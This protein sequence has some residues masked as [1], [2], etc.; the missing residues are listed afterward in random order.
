MV[1][2]PL[3]HEHSTQLYIVKS[4]VF[5]SIQLVCEY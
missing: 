5:W 4:I 1:A 2:C 3:V